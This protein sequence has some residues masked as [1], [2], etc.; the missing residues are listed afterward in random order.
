LEGLVK[1]YEA[2]FVIGVGGGK[3]LDMAKLV[4]FKAGLPVVTIPT[5][6]DLCGVDCAE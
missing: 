6:G 1:S 4:A 3:A 2:D 5:S